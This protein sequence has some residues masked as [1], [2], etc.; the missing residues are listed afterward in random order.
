MRTP[1]AIA[2]LL[3]GSHVIFG[4]GK[5]VTAVETAGWLAMYP[6]KVASVGCAAKAVPDPRSTP[7]AA[8]P[9]AHTNTAHRRIHVF[10]TVRPRPGPCVNVSQTLT[11]AYRK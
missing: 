5:F 9:A 4:T 10:A 6:A 1:T 7:P 8:T 2:R 11:P 3:P